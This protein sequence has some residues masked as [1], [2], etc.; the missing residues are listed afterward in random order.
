MAPALFDVHLCKL[1]YN[2][3][4]LSQLHVRLAS[5]LCSIMSMQQVGQVDLVETDENGNKN[6]VEMKTKT[7][8]VVKTV[9]CVV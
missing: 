6:N 3:S 4:M 5:F 9:H 2:V 7:E 8:K 1:N